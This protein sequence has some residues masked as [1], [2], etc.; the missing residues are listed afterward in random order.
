MWKTNLVVIV[1]VAV[2]LLFLM[3]RCDAEY[4]ENRRVAIKRSLPNWLSTHAPDGKVSCRPHP[5]GYIECDVSSARFAE[6]VT[7]HCYGDGSCS[8]WH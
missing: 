2:G 3:R 8:V 7:I 6:P 1:L 5:G 4:A